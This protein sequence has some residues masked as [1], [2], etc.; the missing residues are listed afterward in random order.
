MKS[1]EIR[2]KITDQAKLELSI[3]EIEIDK[4]TGS[5]VLIKMQPSP[6]IPELLIESVIAMNKIASST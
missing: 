3:E 2:S 1:K 5:E 4:P 6:A